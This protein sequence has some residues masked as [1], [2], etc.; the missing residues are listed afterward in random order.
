MAYSGLVGQIC[1]MSWVTKIYFPVKLTS[2]CSCEL[3]QRIGAHF[4]IIT[5]LTLNI[6]NNLIRTFLPL[7]TLE[8]QKFTLSVS[9]IIVS[10]EVINV[11]FAVVSQVVLPAFCTRNL[12]KVKDTCRTS[13][14][15]LGGVV[16]DEEKVKSMAWFC[17][18]RFEVTIQLTWTRQ[19]SPVLTWTTS[20]RRNCSTI[21]TPSVCS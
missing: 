12:T 8:F 20:I 19:A 4:K 13:L 21:T 7:Q 10:L 3:L 11:Y 1:C 17:V 2:S 9:T 14:W 16:L 18:H 6:F 15:V 5:L